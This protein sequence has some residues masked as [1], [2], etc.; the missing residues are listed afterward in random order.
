MKKYILL[1]CVAIFLVNSSIAQEK[2]KSKKEIKLEKKKSKF[3]ASKKAMEIGQFGFAIRKIVS[4]NIKVSDFAAGILYVRGNEGELDEIVWYK[5]IGE[6]IR[7]FKDFDIKNYNVIASDKEQ[8]MTATYQGLVNNVRYSFTTVISYDK[9]PKLKIKSE[10][11]I[12]IWYT[13]V[14]DTR[15]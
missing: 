6:R 12:E 7:L 4:S 3:E 13:G 8:T 5:A 11:G 2:K 1:L 14:F 10:D 15:N 9:K